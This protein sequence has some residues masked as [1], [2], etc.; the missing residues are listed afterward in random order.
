VSRTIAEVRSILVDRERRCAD[1]GLHGREA[2]RQAQ[3]AGRIPED[4]FGDVFL[5]VDGWFTLRQEFEAAEETARDIAARGL[6]YG[7]HVMISMGRWS[8]LH[9][10]MRDKV[11][12]RLEL[13]LGDP[14]ESGI[15]LRAAAQVPRLPGHGLTDAKLHFLG[16]LPRIDGVQSTKGL[17]TATGEL[18]SAI[19]DNWPGEQAAAV[20]TLPATLHMT[21]LPVPQDLRVAI[22][23][24]EDQLAPVWHDFRAMPHL[25][26][27]GD[28]ESG[29]SNLLRLLTRAITVSRTP[30]QARI[31]AVDYRRQLFDDVPDEYRLGYSVSPDSTRATAAE[32]L[33]GLKPRVPGPEVTPEQLRSR[34]WWAGPELFVLVDDYELLAGHENPLAGL[35]PLLPQGGDI[36]LHL[37]VARAAA[38]AM[39]LSMDPLL[40][41]IQELNTPDVALSC[42]PTEGPLLGG[43]KPRVLPRGRA[44]L[45]TRR[46]SR[47]VQTALAPVPAAQASANR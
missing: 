8:E 34:D 38:G 20:R 36:G 42:P 1:L 43:T 9:M 15:D 26:V 4:R 5:V 16:A 37:I 14:V 7:V 45:C 23:V 3:A 27:L 39:R 24:D 29:K 40:R 33:A 6:N 30:A 46:G 18:V 12:T 25:T 47:L 41:R 13:R 2:Y 35:I 28:T 31:M 10:S 21:E 17:A 19:V 44:L 11:G 32:A 22:G